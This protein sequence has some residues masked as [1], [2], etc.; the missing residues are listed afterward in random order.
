[1]IEFDEKRLSK[2]DCSQFSISTIINCNGYFEDILKW[3]QQHTPTIIVLI[4]IDIQFFYMIIKEKWIQ[5]MYQCTDSEMGRN[6]KLWN[7]C[8]FS[9]ISIEGINSSL[10]YKIN[11][12]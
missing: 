12:K 1:M 11:N 4:N 7:C 9:S 3:L 5:K 6:I 10:L 2:I 8:C